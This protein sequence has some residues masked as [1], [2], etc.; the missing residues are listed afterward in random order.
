MS[1][2]K[3]LPQTK[4]HFQV[5]SAER[6]NINFVQWNCT[7]PINDTSGLAPLPGTVDQHKP[8]SLFVYVVFV[9]FWYYFFVVFLIFCLSVGYSYFE[10]MRKTT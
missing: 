5:M 9:R 1:G 4:R 7:G 2:H 3:I 8:Y 10:T 6:E